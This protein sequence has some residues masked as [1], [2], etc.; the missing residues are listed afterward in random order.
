VVVEYSDGSKI[1]VSYPSGSE[2]AAV[3]ALKIPGIPIVFYPH[4]Q[5][6]EAVMSLLLPVRVEFR[7]LSNVFMQASSPNGG[8]HIADSGKRYFT[9]TSMT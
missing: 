6:G 8:H 9:V 5:H 7:K 3:T 2:P 1:P 4:A